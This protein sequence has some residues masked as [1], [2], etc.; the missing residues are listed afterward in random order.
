M[1]RSAILFILSLLFVLPVAAQDDQGPPDPITTEALCT[2]NGFA[3][4]LRDAAAEFEEPDADLQTTLWQTLAGLHMLQAFCSD[5]VF[6]GMGNGFVGPFDLPAGDYRVESVFENSAT[7]PL[8]TLTDE[9][10]RAFVFKMLLSPGLDG[11]GDTLLLRT[12]A[13]CRVVVEVNT[14]GIW[15]VSFSPLS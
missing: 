12:D 5:F 9:C 10:E 4:F 8:S 6:A 13:D 14:S 15:S 7:A 3:G 1:R 11:G 2:P